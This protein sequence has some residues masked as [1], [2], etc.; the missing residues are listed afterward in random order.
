MFATAALLV[1]FASTW[2]MVGLIWLVQLVHYPL[3]VSIEPAKFADAMFSHQKRIS[4][5][6][7]PLM[8]SELATAALLWI[9]RPTGV[10]GTLLSSAFLLLL[11]AWGSTFLIQVPQHTRLLTGYSRLVCDQ[12][13]SRNWVRT[14]AWSA[15]GIV[16]AAIVWQAISK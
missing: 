12:L 14:F 16:V 2:A 13:V 4:F 1:H 9:V 6:V 11:V 8:V 10:S 15:R 3:F 7:L 5:I